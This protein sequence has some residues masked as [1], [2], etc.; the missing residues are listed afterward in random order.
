MALLNCVQMSSNEGSI[1]LAISAVKSTNIQSVNAAA[2]T[3][4]VSKSTL[5]RRLKG[6][7]AREDYML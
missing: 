5:L 2:K 6:S 3:Y 7:P 1:L 4:G